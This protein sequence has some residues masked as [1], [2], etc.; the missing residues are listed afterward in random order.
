MGVSSDAML[1]FGFRVGGE[2][3]LPE[4]MGEHKHFD[5]FILV[6]EGLPVDLPY[7]K[8]APVIKKCPAELQLYC[9]YEYPMYVLAVRGSEHKVY[10]GDIK[11][12][13]PADLEVHPDKIVA[14]K[15]WCES[16]DIPYET[17]KWLLCSMYG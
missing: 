15:A 3:E 17:P 4:W 5:D 9:A 1:Y 8:R 7:E 10:R 11:E 2:D 6:K 12:I 16:A 13:S 14:F